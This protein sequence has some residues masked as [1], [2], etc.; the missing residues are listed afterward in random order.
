M[1]GKKG[2]SVE[3][4]LRTAVHI[5]QLYISNR[6][7]Y[8]VSLASPEHEN[9]SCLHKDVFIFP[10]SQTLDIEGIPDSQKSVRAT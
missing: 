8:V 1:Y 9:R 2:E 3:Q 10:S 7:K 6:T 5:E 4:N